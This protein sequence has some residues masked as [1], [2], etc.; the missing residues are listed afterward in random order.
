MATHFSVAKDFLLHHPPK[1]IFT[2]VFEKLTHKR[3]SFQH[4]LQQACNSKRGLEIGGPSGIFQAGGYCP[5]YPFAK[6]M[7][8][9]NFSTNTVWEGK[10]EEGNHFKYGTGQTGYQWIQ[11]AT[12]LEKIKDN[13]YDF[14]I[15]SNCLEHSANTLKAVNEWQRVV[16]K[17]G[18]LL[19]ILPKKESNFDHKRTVTT[20]S[21]LL[22]DYNNNIAEDDLTHLPEILRLHDLKRDG[23]AGSFDNFKNRS[24]Q[25]FIYR[26]L[27]HH[28]FDLALLEEI[29][30]YFTMQVMFKESSAMNH[31]IMLRKNKP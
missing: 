20:F 3:I 26:C 14:L 19:M 15:S 2:K 27:H 4:A 29:A 28:V 7:D 24:E 25:N 9:V 30:V 6:Q 17:D 11:E 5:I 8:C 22:E 18:F 13:A 21:H 10:I 16:K 1:I 23:P 31:Y 12:D